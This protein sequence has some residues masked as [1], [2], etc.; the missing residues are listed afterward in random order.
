SLTASEN[1]REIAIEAKEGEEIEMCEALDRFKQQNIEFGEKRG[2]KKGTKL[3][4][5]KGMVESLIMVLESKMELTDQDIE[6][7]K[8]CNIDELTLALQ[9]TQQINKI[10]DLRAMLMN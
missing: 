10:N 7:I 9:H 5:K 2:I 6:F 3:G 4:V 8:G 1:L